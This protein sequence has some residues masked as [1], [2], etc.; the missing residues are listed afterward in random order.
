MNPNRPN[1][2]IKSREKSG[3]YLRTMLYQRSEM[4]PPRVGEIIDIQ[5]VYYKVNGVMHNYNSRHITVFVNK[6]EGSI[7][8]EMED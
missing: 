5:G 8:Q 6:I 2:E 1:I 3:T 7:H 4:E